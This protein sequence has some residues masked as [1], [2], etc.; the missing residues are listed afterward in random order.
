[1]FKLAGLRLVREQVQEG[2][3]EGLYPVKMYVSEFF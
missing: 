1:M 3:P 2:L